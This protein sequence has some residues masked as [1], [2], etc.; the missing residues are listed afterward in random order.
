MKKDRGFGGLCG[1][2]AKVLSIWPRNAPIG[3]D[4]MSKENKR[5]R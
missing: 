3:F 2:S 5:A 1:F 4:H